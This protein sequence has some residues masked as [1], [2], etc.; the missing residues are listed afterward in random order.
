MP[1]NEP[2]AQQ[3]PFVMNTQKEL[4]QAFEEYR[5]TQFGGWPW[6][7]PDQ[8]HDKSEGRFAKYTDGSIVRK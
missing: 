5:L 1:I 7:Y 8:V 3:G 4:A 2:I 6:Q